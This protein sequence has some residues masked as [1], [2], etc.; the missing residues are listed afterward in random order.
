MQK[1]QLL[2]LI[3]FITG[4]CEERTSSK[5]KLTRNV[6]KITEYK[7][8]VSYDSL[9][10]PN[11][12]TISITEKHYNHN[13]QIIK[14]NEKTLFDN[15]TIEIDFIYNAANKLQQEIVK[16]S[17]DTTTLNYYYRNDL[18]DKISAKSIVPEFSFEH[19][20]K[21]KYDWCN[22]LKEVSTTQQ[23]INS[24]YKDTLNTLE[25]EKYNEKGRLRENKF[26]DFSNPKRNSTYLYH[27][28]GD[29]LRNMESYNNQ[30]FLISR[31]YF[32]YKVDEFNN[33]IETKSIE[34]NRLNYIKIRKIEY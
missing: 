2:L 19:I 27:Y 22:N 21:Y 24:E 7:I 10:I 13:N 11:Y 17:L 29:T 5:N 23:I 8:K 1:Y 31:T 6:N 12:D 18:L 32:E 16:M 9:D 3:V 25:V 4:C 28:Q 20:S 30:D 34:N 26:T 14:R 15:E 33:W